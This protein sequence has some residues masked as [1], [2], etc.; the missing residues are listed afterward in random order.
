MS[1]LTR[2]DH[3]TGA[4]ESGGKVVQ[5]PAAVIEGFGGGKP[6]ATQREFAAHPSTPFRQLAGNSANGHSSTSQKL[7]SHP[8]VANDPTGKTF[9]P[10]PSHSSVK[11]PRVG[12]FTQEDIHNHG[13]AMSS[14]TK[15]C[16]AAV[17]N[18][19]GEQP[20]W[21]PSTSH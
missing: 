8:V 15:H 19:L 13:C 5:S 21:R 4:V 16:I 2:R 1:T 20:H 3:P 12:G 11:G 18:S 7:P 10:A 17:L 6:K 14:A 9:D